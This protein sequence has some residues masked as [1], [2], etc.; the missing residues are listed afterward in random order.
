MYERIWT[1]G[2]EWASGSFSRL[3]NHIIVQ[4]Y[5]D[6]DKKKCPKKLLALPDRLRR[7]Q[8]NVRRNPGMSSKAYQTETMET[9]GFSSYRS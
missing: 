6:P 3:W 1:H 9:Y 5:S 4:T 7:R 8:R 2:L